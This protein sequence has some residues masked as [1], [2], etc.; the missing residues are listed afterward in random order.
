M[1]NSLPTFEVDKAGL[2]KLLERKG[3]HFAVAELIQNAWDE[4]VSSVA[5]ELANSAGPTYTLTVTDDSPE[6]FAD[7]RHAYT[8][9]A[10]SA[11]K[12]DPEKRGRFNLGEKLVIALCNFAKIETTKGSV[13]FDKTGRTESKREKTKA[14]SI[15]TGVIPMDDD[16]AAE[17]E[18]MVHRLIPPDGVDTTFNGTALSH[19]TP[20]GHGTSYFLGNDLWPDTR[21]ARCLAFLR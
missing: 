2:A 7:L 18:R 5:V 12:D 3:K 19:R 16:E 6:G 20:P 13:T 21:G 10:E 9:F 8:L 4:N 1:T 17:V 15:F 14:G 11:K